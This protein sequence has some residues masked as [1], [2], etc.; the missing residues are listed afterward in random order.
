[1]ET[2]FKLIIIICLLAS[3]TLHSQSETN[4]KQSTISLSLGLDNQTLKDR[5]FSPT[6][7]SGNT[8]CFGIGFEQNIRDE[9]LWSTSLNGSAGII[10]YKNKYFETNYISAQFRF[11]YLWKIKS[12]ENSKLYFGGQVRSVM[13]ILDY[14]GFASGSWFTSQQLEPMLIYKHKISDKQ[15]ITG[16]FSYPIIGLVGRPK[17]AGVDEFTVINSDNIPEILYSRLKLQSINKLINP[18]LALKYSYEVQKAVFSISANYNY[19][20]VNSVRKYYKNSLGLQLMFQLKIGKQD[21]K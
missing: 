5:T 20:Q 9:K 11:N 19:L 2:K 13:N 18:N 8:P 14:D 16:Q 6:V 10:D 17:Y 12:Y 3:Q 15:S 1:M 21:E 7:F 4:K